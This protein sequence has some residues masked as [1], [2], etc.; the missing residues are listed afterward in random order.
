MGL[1]T[2][3]TE[4]EVIER[5]TTL[6][7]A[8]ISLYEKMDYSEINLSLIAKEADFTRSNVYR[9][10][11]SKE[12]IFREVLLKDQK[13]WKADLFYKLEHKQYSSKQLANIFID[14]F[15]SN[16]RYIELFSILHLDSTQDLSDE[17][18]LEFKNKFLMQLAEVSLYL[19]RTK[20]FSSKE[21]A[22]EFVKITMSLFSGSYPM[23]E[24]MR[25][26]KNSLQTCTFNYAKTLANTFSIL[27]EQLH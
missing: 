22:I 11:S 12:S 6:I 15:L 17:R 4:E 10:F 13:K 21:G 14:S 8:A 23:I 2:A 25:N 26:N 3:L 19:H 24:L 1:N 18:L 7:Y 9:Y 16:R 27:I 5:E 20:N